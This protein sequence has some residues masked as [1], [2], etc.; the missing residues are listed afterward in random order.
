MLKVVSGQLQKMTHQA[1]TPVQYF[2]S[3]GGESYPVTSE[4]GRHVTMKFAGTITCVECG[5]RIKK[6]YNDGYC[7]PCTRDLPENDICSVRPEKCR[8]DQGSEA[9][10]EFYR[11]H[12]NIDHFVY[13][14][15]TSGVKVGITRYWN[16]PGRWID[17]GAVKA[18]IIAKVPRRILSGKIEVALAK[19][20]S[21]RTNWRKMLLGQ[22]E[23]VDLTTLRDEAVEWI[24]EDMKEYALRDEP[25]QAFTYPVQSVPEKISSHNLDKEHEFTDR[26]T[27]IKGQYLIF[28]S[29]V[30]NLRKYAGYHLEF[31]FDQ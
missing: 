1:D 9:D 31:S 24:P 16:I 29:R 3:L 19:K 2:L 20:L 6:T 22:V 10:R 21:D 30:I 17:Q 12:C 4:V 14:S 5:R 18:V 7:F 8:H 15:L 28:E 13:L 23:D 27:G 11:T 26:L 25:V